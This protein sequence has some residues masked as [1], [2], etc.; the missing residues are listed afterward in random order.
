MAESAAA[1]LPG[2]GPPRCVAIADV[3]WARRPCHI[4][5]GEWVQRATS[6]P[7]M[8]APVF[9]SAPRVGSPLP[10]LCTPGV[11]SSLPPWHLHLQALRLW[12]WCDCKSCCAGVPARMCLL[13]LR[14]ARAS[15]GTPP[16]WSSDR[17]T[18]GRNRTPLAACRACAKQRTSICSSADRCARARAVECSHRVQLA[19][20]RFGCL[21]LS[22]LRP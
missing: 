18:C 22:G 19:T 13:E 15:C 16:C 4:H 8:G 7:R 12:L 10:H 1:G 20:A 11:D 14:G 21:R 17:H 6:A 5:A 2:A 3:D 9:P